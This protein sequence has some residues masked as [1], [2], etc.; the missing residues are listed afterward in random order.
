MKIIKIREEINETKCERKWN[1]TMKMRAASLE[2]MNIINKLLFENRKGDEITHKCN[3]K[4]KIDITTNGPKIEQ[5]KTNHNVN[6]YKAKCISYTN[7]T[8]SLKYIVCCPE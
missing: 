2:K 4:F 5:I 3:E 8:L 1:M 7:C 6:L